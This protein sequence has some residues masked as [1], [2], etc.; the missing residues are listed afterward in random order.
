L[1]NN[2]DGY[3]YSWEA[4]AKWKGVWD[5]IREI[6]ITVAI[7]AGEDDTFIL[8]KSEEMAKEI[9]NSILYIIPHAGHSLPEEVPYTFNKKL[10]D[11]LS[12]LG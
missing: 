7:F 2:I 5:H 4:I 6:K 10:T 3:T 9:P 1:N 8:K 11:F 12:S